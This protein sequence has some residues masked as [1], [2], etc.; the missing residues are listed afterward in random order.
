MGNTG[1]VFSRTCNM[2][3][4]LTLYHCHIR[5]GT[6]NFSSWDSFLLSKVWSGTQCAS[7]GFF[8]FFF[9]HLQ[10]KIHQSVLERANRSGNFCLDI[11]NFC[12]WGAIILFVSQACSSLLS[13]FSYLRVSL[14]LQMTNAKQ[15]DNNSTV[16]CW[17]LESQ[18]Q[19]DSVQR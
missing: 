4:K 3:W 9:L 10:H 12:Y 13:S 2:K 8:F 7:C 5:K 11:G 17:F 19:V 14:A 18:V 16:L 6:F 1:K 15:T